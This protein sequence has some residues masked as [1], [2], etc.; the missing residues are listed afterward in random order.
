[1]N[2]RVSDKYILDMNFKIP[3]KQFILDFDLDYFNSITSLEPED[4]NVISDLIKN[5]E[6]I[7][8]AREEH[9]FDK[10]KEEDFTVKDAEN[11]LI[12]LI[13]SVL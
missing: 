13:E 6:F 7:T 5:C 8:I 9:Y 3:S 12:D 11:K 4:K 1:M 2:S 10:L